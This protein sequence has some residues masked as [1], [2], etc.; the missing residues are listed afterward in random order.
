MPPTSKFR[1]KQCIQH[2]IS[3]SNLNVSKASGERPYSTHYNENPG[4]FQ[5]Y[6]L[7]EQDITCFCIGKLITTCIY[8][9]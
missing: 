2:I 7:D 6:G 3:L 9:L 8:D 5:K 1:L 4:V